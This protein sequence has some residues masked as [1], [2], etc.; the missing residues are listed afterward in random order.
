M[1]LLPLQTMGSGENNICP[2]E[3]ATAEV[4]QGRGRQTS[5][6]L[7]IPQ[8][9]LKYKNLINDFIKMIDVTLPFQTL[10]NNGGAT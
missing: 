4:F 2:Y 6:V 9:D 5:H 10:F 7:L 8:R 3:G 1:K